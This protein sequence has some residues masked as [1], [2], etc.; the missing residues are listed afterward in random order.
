MEADKIAAKQCLEYGIKT[1]SKH[2][3]HKWF[4][5]TN[6]PEH[7]LTPMLLINVEKIECLTATNML[8]YLTPCNATVHQHF[9]FERISN[10]ETL[11]ELNA[12]QETI[13]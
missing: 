7:T 9:I 4:I 6:P 13:I 12:V 1:I 5:S 2:G 8:V 10:D 11:A 3:P